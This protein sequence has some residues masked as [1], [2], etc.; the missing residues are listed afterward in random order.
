[1]VNPMLVR[2]MAAALALAGLSLLL[3]TPASARDVYVAGDSFSVGVIDSATGAAKGAFK[4]E[5]AEAA[6][7]TPDGSRIYLVIASVDRVQVLDL[8]TGAQIGEQIKVGDQPL[9]I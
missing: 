9:A 3:S 7:I 8:R 6:A 5:G 2:A 1:M 4:A